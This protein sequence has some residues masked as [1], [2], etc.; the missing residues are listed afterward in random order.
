MT[1]N[2][3]GTLPNWNADREPSKGSLSVDTGNVASA[4]PTGS[5]RAR[6]AL[7]ANADGFQIALK[8]AVFEIR[9]RYCQRP[10]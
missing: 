2:R 9:W 3:M 5:R 8:G 10:G 1:V 6:S 4:S 7:L